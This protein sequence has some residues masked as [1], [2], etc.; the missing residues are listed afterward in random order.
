MIGAKGEAKIG[1]DHPHTLSALDQVHVAGFEIP[2]NDSGRVCGSQA[3]RHLQRDGQCSFH[4]PA[5]VAF[6]RF[7][8]GFSLQQL[9]GDKDDRIAAHS[10][11]DRLPM[12]PRM[13]EQ[14]VY[15]A[16]IRMSDL[17]RKVNLAFKS[18]QRFFVVKQFIAD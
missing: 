16:D 13:P 8:Q 7:S 11:A 3:R 12:I 2:V 4:V 14:L 18:F 17:A 1:D 6:Q 15:P 9:H 10:P 5:W